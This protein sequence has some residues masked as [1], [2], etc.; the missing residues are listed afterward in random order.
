MTRVPSNPLDGSEAETKLSDDAGDNAAKPPGLFSWFKKLIGRAPASPHAVI[1]EAL[2]NGGLDEDSREMLARLP[3]AR[4]EMIE[5]VIAFDQKRVDDVMAPRA[6]VIAVDIDTPLDALVRIFADAGHSR[7]PIYRGDLDDPVGMVHIK[8]VVELISTPERRAAVTEPVLKA[9]RRDLLYAPPSMRITDLLLRMQ[10]SR[11][12]MAL[13]VDEY[14]GTDGLLT[15]EDLVEE[16][17]GEINDEHDE[18]DAPTIT[19]RTTGGW[20]AD[21]RV[22]LEEFAEIAGVDLALDEEDIDTLGGVVFSL[23]GRVP[24][25]GEILIH[26]K[27]Y[28]FEVVGAD[29]RKIR[30]LFIQKKT[31]DTTPAEAA[32]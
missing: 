28:E 8:D 27:G 23:A 14:G 4:R 9:V 24:Q 17:V 2:S 20:E 18:D 25:R 15:I 16:I 11:I 30:K 29:P 31:Q 26:P 22:E 19:A 13:V 7:L 32:E 10:A 12:H 6:D 21:A 3:L 5:R 1:T